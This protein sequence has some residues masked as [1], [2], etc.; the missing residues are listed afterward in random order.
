M[1]LRSETPERAAPARTIFVVA[2]SAQLL[3]LIGFKLVWPFLPLYLH[4]LGVPQDRLPLWSGLLD[5]AEEVAM[6]IAAPIWGVLGDRYGRKIMVVRPLLGGALVIM[7]ITAA[8][9]E[10]V[11]LALLVLAGLLTGVISPLNALVAS[12]APPGQLSKMMGRMLAGVFLANTVGPLTG[13]VIGDA[14]GLRGGFFA[15]AGLLV[16]AA[17]LVILLVREP[18]A[19]R[20]ATAAEGSTTRLRFFSQLRHM[21]SVPGFPA[22]LICLGVLCFAGMLLYPIFPV[23]VPTLDGLPVRG[24]EVQVATAVG[25]ALGVPGITGML[26]SWK[27]HMLADRW[28][29]RR[30]LFWSA[31]VG[32][33]I[34]GSLFFVDSFWLLV[35][36]RAIGGL[37]LGIAQVS[38]GALVGVLAPRDLYSTAYGVAGSITSIATALGFLGGGLVAF[39]LGLHSAFLVSGILLVSVAT[40]GATAL[41]AVRTSEQLTLTDS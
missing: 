33:L 19:Q 30:T 25:L 3:G 29:C 15:G 5:F 41:K 26:A 11:V 32:A 39:L 14:V 6:A 31:G 10:Y 21:L 36:I 7:L 12:A 16:L 35:A 24:G 13:G 2:F 38:I 28:G 4:E 17:V 23:L 20:D 37:F 9:N 34:T 18:K 27:A 40:V 8:P 22:L 1:N